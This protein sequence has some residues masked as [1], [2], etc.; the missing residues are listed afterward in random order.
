M[1]TF[2]LDRVFGHRPTARPNRTLTVG[3]PEVI[4][5]I[6]EPVISP[7]I[8]WLSVPFRRAP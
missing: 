3:G 4:W 7:A 8:T 5:L 2:C 6:A 1:T